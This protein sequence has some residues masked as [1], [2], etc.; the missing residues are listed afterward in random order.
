MALA[1]IAVSAAQLLDLATFTRM[2]T[3]HGPSVEANPIVAFLLTDLG[4]PFVAVTK[5][6]AL[7]VIVAVITVLAGRGAADRHPWVV[8]TVAACAVATGLIGG[9]S[10]AMVLI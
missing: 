2:V 7:A 3:V 8:G 5:V 10:N 4:L 9:L 1:I 6:A